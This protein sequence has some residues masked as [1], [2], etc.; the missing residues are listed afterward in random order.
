LVSTFDVRAMARNGSNGS[1]RP[2][3]AQESRPSQPLQE[4]PN[5]AQTVH[6][7]ETE[8][9]QAVAGL[10]ETLLGITP[11]GSS[12]SFFE[13]GGHSLLAVQLISR[14]RET[15][16]VELPVRAIFDSPTVRQL[17]ESIEALR[18]ALQPEEPS[19]GATEQGLEEG[20]I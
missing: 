18:W 6:A 19:S 9:E 15:F 4:R 14:L 3:H 17:A 12:D 1:E 5:S 8:T 16:G 11:V 20:E 10:F 2:H 13:L 7:P